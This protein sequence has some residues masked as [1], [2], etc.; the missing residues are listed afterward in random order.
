MLANREWQDVL[1]QFPNPDPGDKSSLA[2]SKLSARALAYQS[3][4]DAAD[5]VSSINRSLSIR[6]DVD[7]LL[8]RAKIAMFQSNYADAAGFVN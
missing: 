1:D 8:T 7:G 2:A 6:R 4:G 3:T 5:A